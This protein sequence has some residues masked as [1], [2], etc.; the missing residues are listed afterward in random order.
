MKRQLSLKTIAIEASKIQFLREEYQR[1]TNK[2]GDTTTS[3][4]WI[5]Y[6]QEQLEKISDEARRRGLKAYVSTSSNRVCIDI[7]N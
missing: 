4:Y 1:K 6:T 3:Q 7:E 5:N 2:T